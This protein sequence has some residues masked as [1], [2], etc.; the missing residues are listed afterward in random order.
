MPPF[1][2]DAIQGLYDTWGLILAYWGSLAETTRILI[3][4]FASGGTVYAATKAEETG[5]SA[6]L[7]FVAFSIFSYVIFAGYSFLQ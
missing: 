2:S 4:L 3:A 6:M 1:F 7:F 5:W